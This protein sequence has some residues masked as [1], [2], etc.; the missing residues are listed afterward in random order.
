MSIYILAAI[1]AYGVPAV[2]PPHSTA[3]W[4]LRFDLTGD[5]FGSLTA[6]LTSRGYRPL[7]VSA[8]NKVESN[9]YAGIWEQSK[10]PAWEVDFGLNRPA[11]ERRI[12]AWFKGR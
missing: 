3:P 5:E 11:F 6:T 2:A 10:G 12:R 7:C 4:S 8:F 1:L 9:R